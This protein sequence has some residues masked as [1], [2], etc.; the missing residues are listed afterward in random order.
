MIKLPLLLQVWTKA[1]DLWPPN[2][3]W[4]LWLQAVF[5]SLVCLG[6]LT[7]AAVHFGPFWRDFSDLSLLG[8]CMSTQHPGIP[9]INMLTVF[10]PVKTKE[11]PNSVFKWQ[12]QGTV[13]FT[14]LDFQGAGT[15]CVRCFRWRWNFLCCFYC[16]SLTAS[17]MPRTIDEGWATKGKEQSLR[18]IW[19]FPK[20]GVP[21]IGWFIM[22]NP[23]KM[24][25][26]GVPLFSETPICQEAWAFS[27]GI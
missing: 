20:I 1:L 27:G 23:I 2:V 3:M 9:K 11:Y 8:V 6:V 16:C 14:V 5:Q 19:V 12:I 24:D 4:D 10:F 22:E 17:K 21:Q 7:P 18:M 13:C 25:D 15:C 26:L